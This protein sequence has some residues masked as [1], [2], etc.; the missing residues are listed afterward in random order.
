M[1]YLKERRFLELLPEFMMKELL[2]YNIW[3]NLEKKIFEGVYIRK[4]SIVYLTTEIPY[5]KTQLY[6]YY[7]NGI[8]KLKKWLKTTEKVHFKKL[9]KIII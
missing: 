3:N 5:E 2:S 4:K 9:Y 7:K 8:L 6:E 1:L